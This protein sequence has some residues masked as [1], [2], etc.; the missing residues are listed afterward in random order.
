MLWFF[1]CLFFLYTHFRAIS[2][3]HRHVLFSHGLRMSSP[4]ISPNVYH[5][6]GGAV[7]LLTDAIQQHSIN[8]LAIY[9]NRYIGDTLYPEHALL[10]SQIKHSLRLSLNDVFW[11]S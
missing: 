4:S 6:E 3:N 8:T 11:S 2:I 7:H 1:C 9:I 5:K 10:L